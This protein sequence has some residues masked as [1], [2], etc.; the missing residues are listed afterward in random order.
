ML[1]ESCST[2]HGPLKSSSD[3]KTVRYRPQKPP[4][5]HEITSFDD[6]AR[7]VCRGSQSIKI[8]PGP[9]KVRYIPPKGPELPEITIFGDV[10]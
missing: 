7:I 4:E 8:I 3:H 10:T 2:A 6:V 9:E 1:A 5:H